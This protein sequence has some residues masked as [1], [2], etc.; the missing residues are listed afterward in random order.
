LVI[1]NGDACSKNGNAA[2]S[3]SAS[4]TLLAAEGLQALGS[5]PRALGG[6]AAPEQA[7]QTNLPDGGVAPGVGQ[8]PMDTD[9]LGVVV[10]PRILSSVDGDE[11]GGRMQEP[12]NPGAQ[13]DDIDAMELLLQ[14]LNGR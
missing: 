3:T 4:A 13:V 8:M 1:R 14:P 11:F 2:P 12:H 7:V 9:G 5:A 10:D 6:F